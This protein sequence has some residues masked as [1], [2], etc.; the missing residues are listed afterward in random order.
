MDDTQSV[1][2]STWVI[3]PRASIFARC[4]LT[5]GN[6]AIR[7]FLGACMT[8]WASGPSCI[9]YSPGSLPI[10]GESI[11]EFSHQVISG[12]DALGIWCSC[13]GWF[14]PPCCLSGCCA[15]WASVRLSGHDSTGH[16]DH[17]LP[18][19]CWETQESR[20]RCVCNVPV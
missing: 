10:L 6:N 19:T 1:G 16:L 15:C 11:R 14:C 12:C 20:T 3:T 7:H 18:L 8:R 9:L 13:C 5:L 4:S 2:W 17:S